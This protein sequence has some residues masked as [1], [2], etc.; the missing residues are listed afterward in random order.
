MRIGREETNVS[1]IALEFTFQRRTGYFL[2]QVNQCGRKGFSENFQNEKN[3][4]N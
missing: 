3:Q 4:P 2:L 1:I